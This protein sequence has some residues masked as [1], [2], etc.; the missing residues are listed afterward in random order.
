MVEPN[1]AADYRFNDRDIVR[2]FADNNVFAYDFLVSHGLTWTK[3]EPDAAGG[4]SVGNSVPR[5]MHAAVMAWPQIQTGK[6]VE[7]ERQKRISGG[8]GMVRPLEA[9]ARKVGVQILL[10]HR[11]TSIIRE[12][13][14]TG[15]VV[16]ITVENKGAKLNIRARKGVI[17]CTGGSTSN[18]NFRR[19]FDPRLTE[20]YCG[21]AGESYTAHR[22]QRRNCRDG[23]RGIA[24]GRSQLCWGICLQSR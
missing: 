1:G 24:L 18:V 22:C 5:T 20:E 14:N 10:Q 11:M 6:A 15:R 12:N 2:A 8:I 13:N 3:P 21:T 7:P 16:G 17:I 23:R 19:I 4:T 9:A